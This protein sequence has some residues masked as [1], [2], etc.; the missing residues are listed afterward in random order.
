MWCPEVRPARI[1][2]AAFRRVKELC[3]VPRDVVD[4]GWIC[5]QIW[6]P[7]PPTEFRWRGHPRLHQNGGPR[8]GGTNVVCDP[9]AV[10]IIIRGN[11]E[12]SP[13]PPSGTSLLLPGSRG[14]SLSGANRPRPAR[15][16]GAQPA[17]PACAGCQ[18]RHVT[19]RPA[20]GAGQGAGEHRSERTQT[21]VSEERSRQRRH[22]PAAGRATGRGTPDGL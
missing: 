14:R 4:P 5:D 12:I 11:T 13:A 22:A 21:S 10:L 8:R 19:A 1:L 7:S 20:D 15:S 6:A 16:D 3:R 18:N 2:A 9:E 17:T